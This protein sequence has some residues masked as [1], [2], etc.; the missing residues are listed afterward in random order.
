MVPAGQV[1]GSGGA[2]QDAGRL[3]PFVGLV[4]LEP[5]LTASV[6][7]PKAANTFQI[8]QTSSPSKLSTAA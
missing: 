4:L 2:W 5:P 3:K 7:R 1:G 6:P 8:R